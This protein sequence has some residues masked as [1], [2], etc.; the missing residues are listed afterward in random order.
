MGLLI[1]T[2]LGIVSLLFT[3][4]CVYFLYLGFGI[5]G[6]FAVFL[7]AGL[8]VYLMIR[9]SGPSEPEGGWWL[10]RVRLNETG[11][12]KDESRISLQAAQR[13]NDPGL[14]EQLRQKAACLLEHQLFKLSDEAE[15]D[16]QAYFEAGVLDR[17]TWQNSRE[18]S[19]A[20]NGKARGGYVHYLKFEISRG[21]KMRW[22]G[23]ASLERAERDSAPFLNGLLAAA[24]DCLGRAETRPEL[25]IPLR[26]HQYV[27]LLQERFPE[28][29]GH[30]QGQG[31]SGR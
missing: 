30:G 17:E 1:K 19:S 28:S 18:G 23:L 8:A 24:F 29:D 14:A 26:E 22:G 3:G 4:A 16:Y 9:F 31:L 25:E 20:R 21:G 2:I 15:S 6:T 7:A 11:R 5:A 10:A 27:E 13:S 12:I